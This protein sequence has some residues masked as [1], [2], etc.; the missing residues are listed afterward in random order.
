LR[1]AM[2]RVQRFPAAGS[3]DAPPL[4]GSE[5][6]WAA[7]LR[8]PCDL[9]SSSRRRPPP[10][11][12]VRHGCYWAPPPPGRRSAA[13]SDDDGVEDGKGRSPTPRPLP[14]AQTSGPG[15]GRLA[16]A[17]SSLRLAGEPA[18]ETPPGAAGVAAG[19]PGAGAAQGLTSPRSPVAERSPSRSPVRAQRAQSQSLSPGA[20]A[21]RAAGGQAKPIS[22]THR[23]ANPEPAAV[24]ART[25][26]GGGR[27]RVSRP[28]GRVDTANSNSPR[29]G[30]S[31]SGGCSGSDGRVH[32]LRR[33]TE[34]Q[35]EV[36]PQALREIRA[37]R[38]S[39]CW[40]WFV[41]PT[42]PHVVNGVERGSS[43]NRK[44]AL[45]GDEAARAYLAFE[46]DG[47]NLRTNYLEIMSAVRDQLQTGRKASSLMGA[48]D[49]PKLRSSAR[50]FERI[51]RDTGDEELHSVLQEVLDLLQAEV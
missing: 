34:A 50:L 12:A 51:T 14:S 20:V 32:G 47:V 7:Q 6:A 30:G 10:P 33:F 25:E 23:R 19:A 8:A 29:C 39:S 24:A 18:G 49:A 5:L 28:R 45:R 44:Y 3:A 35:R 1:K 37:G 41:V 42:P 9:S 21:A 27:G 48:F 26:D 36:F 22:N 38:K 15:G 43:W 4:R 13:P 2:L 40:M 46:A 11:A 17:D 31:A 16:T